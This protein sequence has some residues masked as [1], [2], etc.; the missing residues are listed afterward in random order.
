[1]RWLLAALVVAGCTEH[2]HLGDGGQLPG[3][4]ALAIAPG[5]IT[6]ELADIGASQRVA[7]AATGTFEDGSSRDV[8]AKVVWSVDN[9]YPGAFEHP[10]DYLATGAAAGKVAIHATSG[11]VDATA[12]LVVHVSATVVDGVFP[13]PAG[14]QLFDG[15]TVGTD[16]TKTPVVRYPAD[17]VRFPQDMAQ[18]VFQHEFGAGN[19]TVRLVFASDVLDL[20]ILTA[21]DRYHPDAE[22]WKLIEASH[23]GGMATLTI[24]AADSTAPG[25]IYRAPPITLAFSSGAIG[26]HAYFFSST[27]PGVVRGSLASTTAS[28]VV[29]TA[30]DPHH[31]IANDGSV[32][33]FADPD[34][35][36]TFDLTSLAALLP[37]GVP[38]GYAAF[39]PDGT[40]MVVAD[41]GNL[42]LRDVTTGDPVGPANGKI[43]LGGLK[44]THPDWSPDGHYLAL[45][46]SDML[47]N[48][49]AKHA[50]IARIERLEDG[51]WGT[52]EILVQSTGDPDNNFAPRWGPEGSIAYIHATS[53]SKDAKS[54]EIRLLPA[55]GTPITLAL[56]TTR[57]GT[58]EMRDTNVTMPT[59]TTAADGTSWL[60][61][62][63][64]RPYGTIRPVKGPAQIWIAGVDLARPDPSFAAFWLP[65]QDVTATGA[66]P[67]FAPLP[68]T[69]Q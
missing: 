16:P 53:G 46:V 59:W 50:S 67:V 37:P 10:G 48:K 6:I 1:M 30:E 40:V 19:D 61:F 54:A 7:Y 45:A 22:V 9:P 23:P 34:K 28:G 27:S 5:D 20:V 12:A 57:I 39:S 52:L 11:D 21:G 47:D 38:M 41:K 43:D 15:A 14:N 18:I 8:T 68:I 13:P 35:L 24:E 60:A 26:D 64:T 29:S 55:E 3:L 65:C 4:V 33:A 25:T 58:E 44:G 42:T 36:Q 17:G 31:A 69:N 63:S 2:V 62:T 49:D 66:N 32:M 51:S 56:A